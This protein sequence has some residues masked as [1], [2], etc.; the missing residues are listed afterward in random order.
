LAIAQQRLPTL[1]FTATDMIDFD[2]GCRFDAVVCLFS[3]I[4]Y[5]GTL[6]RL[7][8]T[9]HTFARHLE[10]GGVVLVEPWLTPDA[11]KPG[12][13]QALLAEAPDLKMVRVSSSELRPDRWV[14]TFHYLVGTPAGVEHFTEQHE[15]DCSPRMHISTP[16]PTLACTSTTIPM[17]SLGGAW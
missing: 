12:H 9:A 6:N 3:S 2:L 11:F 5:V 4:G 1:L 7:R 13:V 15:L 14:L 8:L 17:G 10:P 16:S